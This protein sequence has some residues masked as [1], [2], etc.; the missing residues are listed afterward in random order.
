MFPQGTLLADIPLKTTAT[1][2]SANPI[3]IKAEPSLPTLS[4]REKSSFVF[5]TEAAGVLIDQAT[6]TACVN[7]ARV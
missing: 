7:K 1:S 5:L 3:T 2:K 6:S 4:V